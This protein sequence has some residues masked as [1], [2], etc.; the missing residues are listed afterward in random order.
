MRAVVAERAEALGV[1]LRE[2]SAVTYVGG[3][4]GQDGRGE[5]WPEL[6]SA[7][8]LRALLSALGPGWSELGCHPGLGGD[9]DSTYREERS[10]EVDVLCDPEVRRWLDDEGIALA[11]FRELS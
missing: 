3:F 9:T 7:S 6:L 1:P 4:Y 10:V 5:S 2:C 11:S 8:S